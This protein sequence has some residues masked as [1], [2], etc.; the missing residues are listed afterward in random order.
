MRPIMNKKDMSNNLSI[1]H[2][3][4]LEIMT[5]GPMIKYCQCKWGKRTGWRNDL[6]LNYLTS[7]LL[8]LKN[9][10]LWVCECVLDNRFEQMIINEAWCNIHWKGVRLKRWKILNHFDIYPG[11]SRLFLWVSE[12]ACIFIGVTFCSASALMMCGYLWAEM[13]Y[14]EDNKSNSESSSLSHCCIPQI[15]LI[16]IPLS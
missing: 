1:L 8:L 6:S 2:D 16:I 13:K 5:G 4:H 11:Y 10:Y 3:V 7:H 14:S 12:C 15:N 9:L